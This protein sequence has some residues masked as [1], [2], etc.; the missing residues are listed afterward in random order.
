MASPGS[1]EMSKAYLEPGGSFSPAVGTF[2]VSLWLTDTEGVIQAT[3]DSIPV[4]QIHQQFVWAQNQPLPSVLTRTRHYEAIWASCGDDCWRLTLKPQELSGLVPWLVIR[5]VGPAGGPIHSMHWDGHRLFVQNDEAPWSITVDPTPSAVYL[6]EEGSDGWKTARPSVNGFESGDGWAYSRIQLSRQ[7]EWAVTLRNPTPQPTPSL[8]F[9]TLCSTAAVELPDPQFVA[10]FNAQ[11]AHLMMGL[12]RSETRPG[13]PVNYPLAWLRDGA[14]SVTALARAGQLD[15]AKQLAEY[16][17]EHD[18]FGGFGPEA[19]APGLSLWAMEEVATRLKQPEFDHW[20]WPHVYRKAEFIGR[21]LAADRP[22][23]ELVFGPIVPAQLQRPDLSLVCDPARQGLIVGRMDWHRPV[24]SISA[25]S[26]RGLLSAAELA[27]RVGQPEAA[28]H[29]RAK[30]AALKRAWEAGFKPPESEDEDTF[31]SGL[32][33]TGIARD[34]TGPYQQD[35][36]AH[37][38]KIRDAQGGFLQTPLWTYF[39]IAEAHQWL[40][41]GRPE[42]TWLTLR[43]YWDHQVS[44]GLYTWWEGSGEENT[45]HLWEQVRGWLKPPYVTPHYWTAAEMLLLQLDMLAYVDEPK[46]GTPSLVVGAGIPPDWCSHTMSVR[47]L[48]TRLGKIDWVWKD[49]QMAV[50]VHGPHCVARLGPSFPSNTPL[51]VEYAVGE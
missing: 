44:P 6:G 33:P 18:F 31:I 35:L 13:D 48:P 23:H 21:M 28:T 17:A 15:V 40:F 36:E 4:D 47:G 9:T 50:T 7:C 46:G 3:S 51:S 34:V 14:Y 41:L 27:E 32:W 39:D 30:A 12:V 37:W 26:Y 22:V 2:G 16:F 19:D 42:R 38:N 49:G 1:W 10:S 20:L 29:W 8:H 11:V 43:W 45:F 25:L 24:L 5:S